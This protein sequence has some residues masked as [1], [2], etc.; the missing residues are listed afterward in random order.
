MG[1]TSAWLQWS[2]IGL[3]VLVPTI[4]NPIF[5]CHQKLYCP[6]S[7]CCLLRTVLLS[8]WVPNFW[9]VQ[10]TSLHIVTTLHLNKPSSTGH[11]FE[12]KNLYI[13]IAIDKNQAYWW[14]WLHP[15]CRYL[16][17]SQSLTCLQ[18]CQSVIYCFQPTSSLVTWQPYWSASNHVIELLW[19]YWLAG[20]S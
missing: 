15:A 3:L 17:N 14:C 7:S 16:S 9:I 12:M 4:I 19:V 13:L 11:L 20:E 5:R 6:R 18:C 10:P 8:C 1:L 2:L